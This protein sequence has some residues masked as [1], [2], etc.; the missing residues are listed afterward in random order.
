MPSRTNLNDLRSPLLVPTHKFQ[1]RPPQY[2]IAPL[3]LPTPDKCLPAAP[4]SDHWI[5]ISIALCNASCWA[6]ILGKDLPP[7]DAQHLHSPSTYRWPWVS[8][9][10]FL[11]HLLVLKPCLE[12]T[13]WNIAHSVLSRDCTGIRLRCCL[14]PN[15]QNGDAQDSKSKNEV[16]SKVHSELHAVLVQCV[17]AMPL[18]SCRYI[19]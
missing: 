2:H 8:H 10:Y 17:F 11:W 5:C 18:L 15:S 16:C 3:S 1:L 13:E 12:C 7:S 4:S 14:G 6:E 19:A 9:T